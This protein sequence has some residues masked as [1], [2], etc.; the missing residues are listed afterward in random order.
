MWFLC[1]CVA[2]D[3]EV[4]YSGCSQ[5]YVLLLGTALKSAKNGCCRPT[6][7]LFQDSAASVSKG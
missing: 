5:K 1:I 6:G 2:R 4:W 3:I 7:A